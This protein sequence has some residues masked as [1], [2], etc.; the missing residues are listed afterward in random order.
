MA[1]DYCP[2]SAFPSRRVT[3]VKTY[4]VLG[5]IG[6]GASCA[7]ATASTATSATV[8][9]APPAPITL[10]AAPSGDAWAGRPYS[11]YLSPAPGPRTANLRFS[12]MNL[13]DWARLSSLG[14]VYGTPG[15]DDIGLYDQITLVASDGERFALLGPFSITVRNPEGARSVTVSWIP[16][17]ENTDGTPLEDLAGYRIE[18]AKFGKPFKTAFRAR[19]ATMSRVVLDFLEPGD[20]FF[21]IFAIAANGVE[22]APSRFIYRRID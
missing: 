4:C 10:R 21:R 7:I 18:Y 15:S 12:S 6:L 17:R 3:L 13:P 20:Y 8:A 1:G 14:V 19:S 5:L 11:F 22:S 16:P 9:L 2:P